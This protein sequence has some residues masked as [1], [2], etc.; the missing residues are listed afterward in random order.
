MK[1]VGDSIVCFVNI[2]FG[3]DI[4]CLFIE[5]LCFLSIAIREVVNLY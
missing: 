5:L 4:K 3:L 2:K 1:N